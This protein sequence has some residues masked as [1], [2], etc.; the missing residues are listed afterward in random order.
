MF[1]PHPCSFISDITSAI[2]WNQLN[3]CDVYSATKSVVIANLLTNAHDDKSVVGAHLDASSRERLQC[4]GEALSVDVRRHLNSVR[5]LSDTVVNDIHLLLL[6]DTDTEGEE[7]ESDTS[8]LVEKAMALAALS[9]AQAPLASDAPSAHTAAT[10]SASSTEGSRR[11]LQTYL[12]AAEVRVQDILDTQL[13]A[14]LKGE[15]N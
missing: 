2:V 8:E 12:S 15:C 7:I 14:D 10:G 11:L 1:S 13:T 9:V 5:F 3:D 6:C 4:F